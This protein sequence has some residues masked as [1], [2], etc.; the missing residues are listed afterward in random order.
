MRPNYKE[1]KKKIALR[2]LPVLIL[3][4]SL[5]LIVVGQN[6]ES[7]ES[8]PV[9]VTDQAMEQVVRRILVWYFKP[10]KQKKVI[11]LAEKG[12]QKPW[13]PRIEGVEFWLLPENEVAEKDG[14]HFFY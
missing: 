8:V 14:V 6:E 1:I 13:L 7:N 5:S 12:L 11:Y 2:F 10:R 4:F 9:A 3:F